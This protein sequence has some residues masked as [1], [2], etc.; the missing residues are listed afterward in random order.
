MDEA[1]LVA[2]LLEFADDLVSTDTLLIEEDV[3]KHGVLVGHGL[4]ELTQS[5]EVATEFIIGD[6]LR[7]TGLIESKFDQL[8]MQ[9]N[10]RR[11]YKLT[12]SSQ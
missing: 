12:L 6:P 8:L 10:K 2:I 9:V 1:D 3:I 7:L 5:F 4:L 11:V